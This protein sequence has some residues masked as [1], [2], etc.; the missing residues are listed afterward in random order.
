MNARR[1]D[2]GADQGRAVL[3]ILERLREHQRDGLTIVADLVVL[4]RQP[5]RRSRGDGRR[6][7]AGEVLRGE[8]VRHRR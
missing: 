4:E 6:P 1:L 3:G 7:E 2:V 5:R 8:D